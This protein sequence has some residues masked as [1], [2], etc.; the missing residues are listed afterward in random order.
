MARSLVRANLGSATATEFPN[1]V[2]SS[3]LEGLS[4]QYLGDCRHRISAFVDTYERSAGSARRHFAVELSYHGRSGWRLD[5]LEFTGPPEA[6]TGFLV[7]APPQ[8]AGMD[9]ARRETG[10][11]TPGGGLGDFE[12]P[13][14]KNGLWL[15]Y[16]RRVGNFR[17]T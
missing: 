17:Q 1:R 2:A 12:K 10:L 7:P 6:E 13:S 4:F 14:N 3:G 11:W 9:S 5:R 15:R 16:W 8:A